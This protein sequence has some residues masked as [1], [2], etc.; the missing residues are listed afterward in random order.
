MLDARNGTPLCKSNVRRRLNQILKQ[1]NLKPAGLHAF[2]HGRRI[3]MLQANGVPGALVKEWV[4]HSSLR[5][6]SQY[7]HFR[8][9][10][11]RQTACE[12]GLFAQ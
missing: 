2:R 9:D 1:L 4:G 7:T 3:S 12:V 5:T 8:D 10:F 6:T 11:R